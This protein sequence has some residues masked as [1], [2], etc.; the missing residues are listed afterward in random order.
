MTL[1]QYLIA[2]QCTVFVVY[3]A[4]IWRTFGVLDSISASWY[5]LEKKGIYFTLFIWALAIPTFIIGGLKDNAWYALSGSAL[6][7][8][9]AATAYKEDMTDKV[10]GLGAILGIAFAFTGLITTGV[11][12]PVIAWFVAAF[13]LM[14]FDADDLT[15]WIEI[16]AF[17]SI[18]IGL[19]I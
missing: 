19:L 10:H 16:A 12:L 15:W 3:I 17:T 6:A 14:I 5:A 18:E 13:A 4:A 11:Y 7:F 1:L 8:V 2:F 9:G